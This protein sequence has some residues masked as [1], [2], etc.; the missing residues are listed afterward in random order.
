[1]PMAKFVNQYN[2]VLQA[3]Q[4]NRVVVSLVALSYQKNLSIENCHTDE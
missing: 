3:K 1:M 2:V 4:V